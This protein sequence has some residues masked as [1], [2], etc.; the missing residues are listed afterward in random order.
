MPTEADE[1]LNPHEYRRVL[2][3]ALAELLAAMPNEYLQEL[4]PILL[5]YVAPFPA[6]AGHLAPTA[7]RPETSLN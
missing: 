6:R 2:L 5:R 1:C 4:L 3:E 7:G